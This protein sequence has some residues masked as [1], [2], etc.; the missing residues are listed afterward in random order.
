MSIEMIEK[1]HQFQCQVCMQ[2]LTLNI[3][4]SNDDKIA[5]LIEHQNQKHLL[6]FTNTNLTDLER[7]VHYAGNQIY[8]DGK[9]ESE[10]N[11]T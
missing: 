3:S 1:Y 8:V 6:E 4:T 11:S 10:F 9:P 5:K 2:F 7:M